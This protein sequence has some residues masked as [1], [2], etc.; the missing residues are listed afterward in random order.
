MLFFFKQ[1]T[2]YEMSISDW[3]SDVCS[4]DL[5]G[6][7]QTPGNRSRADKCA[8]TS[9]NVDPLPAIDGSK[10]IG[11]RRRHDTAER[12]SNHDNRDDRRP[13]PSGH[14]LYIESP[15]DREHPPDRQPTEETKQT[16]LQIEIGS[17][18][19]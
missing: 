16:H 11:E 14:K 10:P 4:S 5:H 8:D 15:R 17:A 13:K 1:K 9:E 18:Q 6:F 3:S 12:K 2:A 7:R 19:A